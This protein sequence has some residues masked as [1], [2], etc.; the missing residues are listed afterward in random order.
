[1]PVLGL[2][3]KHKYEISLAIICAVDQ[4]ALGN[5]AL[6]EGNDVKR[7]FEN[8]SEEEFQKTMYIAVMKGQAKQTATN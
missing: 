8:R 1:M 2:R 4:C 3:C 7:T 5:F 6:L